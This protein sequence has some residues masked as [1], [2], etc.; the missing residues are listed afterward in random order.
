VIEIQQEAIEKGYLE[1]GRSKGFINSPELVRIMQPLVG[2]APFGRIRGGVPLGL[3]QSIVAVDGTYL[4]QPNHPDLL[5]LL[6]GPPALVTIGVWRK[7][8][9]DHGNPE[10]IVDLGWDRLD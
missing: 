5:P 4:A 8:G 3:A 1:L 2:E 7:K 6:H 9:F 10:I